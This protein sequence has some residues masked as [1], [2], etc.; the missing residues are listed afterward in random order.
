M[1]EVDWLICKCADYEKI[2][3]FIGV[4]AKKLNVN[5]DPDSQCDY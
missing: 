1:K 4:N 3:G 5:I 2:F